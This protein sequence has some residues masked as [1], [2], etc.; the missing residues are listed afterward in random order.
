MR[1]KIVLGKQ[2]RAD[3]ESDLLL[4]YAA[5]KS[6][7]DAGLKKL[8]SIKE[9]QDEYGVLLAQK[10]RDHK[11]QTAERNEM[12]QLQRIKL[13]VGKLLYSDDD[14]AQNENEHDC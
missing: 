11:E 5:K 6:F 2:Y 4:H 3:H 8:P 7:N 14:R 9:L 12:R 10:K 1:A 13:A